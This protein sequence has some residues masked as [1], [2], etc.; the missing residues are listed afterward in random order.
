MIANTTGN[1]ADPLLLGPANFFFESGLHLHCLYL[2]LVL[3]GMVPEVVQHARVMVEGMAVGCLTDL[4][5]VLEVLAM[6]LAP[7]L[8]PVVEL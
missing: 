8:V 4:A 6:P 3:D 1:L 7:G 5:V 2:V